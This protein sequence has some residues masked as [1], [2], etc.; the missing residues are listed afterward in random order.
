MKII[1]DISEKEYQLMK[2]GHIPFNILD[3]MM[4]GTPLPKGHWIPDKS[5]PALQDCSICGALSIAK[6][7]YCSNCGADM[8]GDQE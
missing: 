3:K 8:R 1:I 5:R 2:G 6:T 7:N 4:N